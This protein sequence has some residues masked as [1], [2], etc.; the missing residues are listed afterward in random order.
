[1]L[2]FVQVTVRNGGT[3]DVGTFPLAG[4]FTDLEGSVFLDKN[5]NGKRDGVG[6]PYEEPGVPELRAD[7]AYPGQHAE[8]PGPASATTDSKGEWDD[9][10]PTRSASS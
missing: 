3:V 5:A 10:R 8:R 7:V 2:D 6:T 1:M 9:A 4:W